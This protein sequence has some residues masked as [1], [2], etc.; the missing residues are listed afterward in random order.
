MRAFVTKEIGAVGMMERLVPSPGP[1]DA[2]V[3]T[4]A[5]LTCTSD[6]HAIG[7]GMGPRTM[8]KIPDGVADELAV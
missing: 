1:N 4:T 6:F 3:K 5:A 8:A 2:I 7:G